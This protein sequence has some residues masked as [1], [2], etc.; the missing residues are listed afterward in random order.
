M[1]WVVDC[2][3]VPVVLLLWPPGGVDAARRLSRRRATRVTLRIVLLKHRL[4]VPSGSPTFDIPCMNRS[5]VVRILVS[6]VGG[7]KPPSR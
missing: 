5:V 4:P 2:V 6:A 3:W 1:K 7:L